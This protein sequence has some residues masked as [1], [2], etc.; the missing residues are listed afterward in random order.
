[1]APRR[2][3]MSTLIG[4]GSL[5]EVAE[6]VDALASGASVRKGVWVRIPSSVPPLDRE[7]LDGVLAQVAELVYAYV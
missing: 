1:M 2:R 3:Q 4:R 5:A 6:S 7:S